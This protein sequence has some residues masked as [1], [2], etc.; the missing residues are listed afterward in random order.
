M[1]P[2]KI[3]KVV[4]SQKAINSLKEHY[5]YIKKDSIVAA[6]KVKAEILLASKNLKIN[7]E[8]YQID[9]YYPNNN[10]NI[11]R[12]FRWNFRIIFEITD[13]QVSIF[14]CYTY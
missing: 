4:W 9:E 3:R 11:R 5:D 6:R 7:P 2:Q 12:L 8:R 1:K 10:G 14:K 13:H